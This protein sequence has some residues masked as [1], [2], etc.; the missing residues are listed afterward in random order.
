MLRD[1]VVK[2]EPPKSVPPAEARVIFNGRT[3]ART[4]AATIIDLA[5]RGY[6]T[7]AEDVPQKRDKGVKGFSASMEYVMTPTNKESIELLPYE[8]HFLEVIFP[9][10]S[11]KHRSFSTRAVTG[12]LSSVREFNWAMIGIQEELT[13]ETAADT[14][15]YVEGRSYQKSM[16]VRNM[17]SACILAALLGLWFISNHQLNTDF[18]I[19][20]VMVLAF[21]I[22]TAI[23]V[24]KTFFSIKY[25]A[26]G[27]NLRA[28]LFAFRRYLKT[29]TRDH[30]RELAPEKFE[31][32]LPYAIIFSVNENWV[33]A[34]ANVRMNPPAWYQSA[35]AHGLGQYADSDTFDFSAATL[36]RLTHRC[37]FAFNCITGSS[38]YSSDL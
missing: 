5:M 37:I 2:D 38:R 19:Y 18:S 9:S 16:N 4:W 29:A 22:V 27:K 7:I 21:I 10:D 17:F 36:S 13:A 8:K 11:G 35:H 33:R 34:F 20:A 28:H 23:L 26:A 1:T 14:K 6:V 25:T 15:A 12:S 32:Y 24:H 31:K 3:G 30:D